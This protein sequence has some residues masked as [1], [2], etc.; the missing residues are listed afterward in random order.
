MKTIKG[1][2]DRVLLVIC[3]GMGYNPNDDK[4]NAV[5]D[6]KTPTL[7]HLISNYPFTTL[8]PGGELVG[9]PK[10][11]AGNSE[12]GHMNLGAGRS[13]RQDLVRINEAIENNTFKDLEK[14][15]KLILKAKENSNRIHLMGLLSDGGVHSHIDHLEHIVDILKDTGIKVYLHAFMDGRDTPKD[16]GKK[17]LER[18]LKNENIIF[19][20]MQGRSIGMDRD[21]RWD[22]IQRAYDMMTGSATTDLDP[23]SYLKSE[24]DKD[25]FDEFITPALFLDEGAIKN[26]DCVLFFNFRPDRAKQISEVYCSD[27]FSE[28]KNKIRPT[29]FLCMSPYIDEEFPQVP[30]LFNREKV[31]GTLCEYLSSLNK[32]TFKI[33]ETEKYAHVTYF[34]N[35]GIEPPFNGEKRV[36]IDSPKDVETY[37]QKPQ[38]SAPQV[39]DSLLENLSDKSISTYI[40]NFANP[41]M[42]GHTGNYEA[43][44]LAMQEIDRCLLELSKKCKSENIAMLITADHGNCDQ[45]KY[46]D[47]SVHTSHSKADVPFILFHKDLENIKIN[48]KDSDNALKDVSPT[49]L[50]LLG[51]EKAPLMEGNSVFL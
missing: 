7:D 51:I 1:L 8:T 14:F 22:K 4:F 27:K 38:M 10:G 41:D 5:K 35:G 39:L 31:A 44:V 37:D 29:Y 42:V 17:Y 9:L 13:V 20:S 50:H 3:D 23:L 32:N 28:F 33:A 46:E 47:G 45:M 15:Q 48:T 19:A 34:F 36:L 26:D 18:I 11:V 21:R 2:T 24:Y 30:I 25:I 43:S 40:V 49:I 6:A 12:V 16:N